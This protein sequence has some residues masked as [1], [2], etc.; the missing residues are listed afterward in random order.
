MDFL[1]NQYAGLAKLSKTV[2]VLDYSD[3]TPSPNP[4]EMPVGGV[5]KSFTQLLNEKVRHFFSQFH[6][7]I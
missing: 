7:S 5:N 3:E 4:E 2:F 1:V 6:S